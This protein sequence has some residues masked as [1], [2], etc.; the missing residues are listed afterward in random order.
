MHQWPWAL[1][2]FLLLLL[3]LLIRGAMI[4]ITFSVVDV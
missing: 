4:K 2:F 1:F 3:L